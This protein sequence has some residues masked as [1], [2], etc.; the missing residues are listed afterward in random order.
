MEYKVGDTVIINNKKCN[1]IYGPY[2]IALNYY[3]EVEDE[4]GKVYPINTKTIKAQD[5]NYKKKSKRKQ[6]EDEI[7]EEEHE[8]E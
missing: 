5:G 8:C 3:F 4:D 6:I 1:L 7:Q 2:N